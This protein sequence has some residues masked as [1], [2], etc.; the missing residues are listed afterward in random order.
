VYKSRPKNATGC[1]G[2]VSNQSFVATLEGRMCQKEKKKKKLGP[3]WNNRDFIAKKRK[4]LL[5]WK[6]SWETTPG[7]MLRFSP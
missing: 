4:S 7:N 6:I 3:Y 1:M 5:S 2:V